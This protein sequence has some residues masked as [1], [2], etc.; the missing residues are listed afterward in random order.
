M[1]VSGCGVPKTKQ[2]FVD[3]STASEAPCYEVADFH[4]SWPIYRKVGKHSQCIACDRQAR[5]AECSA[6]AQAHIPYKVIFSVQL[7]F[8]AAGH[9]HIAYI[10][11]F[12][13]QLESGA[14]GQAR[15]LS[16]T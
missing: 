11:I 7:G 2:W 9:A 3:C 5:A 14:A 10:V 1:C 12:N 4:D 13:V 8:S 15:V 6:A 16:N